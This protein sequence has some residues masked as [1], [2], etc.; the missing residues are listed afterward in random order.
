MSYKKFYRNRSEAKI[1]GVCSGI[2]HYFEV[3]PTLIRILMC[4]LLLAGGGGGLLY[5]IVWIC[6]SYDTEILP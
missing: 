5:I 4:V 6:S 2:A 3:D 1:A